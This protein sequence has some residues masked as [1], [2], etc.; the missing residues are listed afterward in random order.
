MMGI[1]DSV[2]EKKFNESLWKIIVLKVIFL[3]LEV[4]AV[5]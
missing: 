1:F 5:W 2:V 4:E 3:E